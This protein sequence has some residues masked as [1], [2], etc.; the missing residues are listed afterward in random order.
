MNSKLK[1]YSFSVSMIAAI[2]FLI[3]GSF[4]IGAAQEGNKQTGEDDSLI[5]AYKQARTKDGEDSADAEESRFSQRA[6]LTASDGAANDEFG[7][8]VAISGDTAVVS[9]WHDDIGTNADQGSAY[10]FVR[11]GASWILQQKLTASDGAAGDNFGYSVAV[12]NVN[13]PSQTVIM[14]GAYGNDA[15]GPNRGAVYVFVR[16]QGGTSWSQQGKL[17]APDGV[18]N[19]AFGNAVAMSGNFAIIGANGVDIGAN[20]SS[21]AAY[22]F[23]RSGTIWVFEQKL[24]CPEG[25][26]TQRNFGWS[27]SIS[28]TL[29]IVGSNHLNSDQGWAYVF[30]RVTGGNTWVWRIGFQGAGKLGYSVG[31]SGET[32][33]MSAYGADI[34]SNMDQG[35][36]PV[37]CRIGGTWTYQGTLMASDGAANDYFGYNIAISGDR[38][39]VGAHADDVSNVN[40][41]SAYVFTR[42]GT[43]WSQRQK[44]TA[45][46]NGAGDFFAW[47]VAING[48]TAIMGAIFDDIGANAN[49][50]SAYIFNFYNR[51]PFDFDGDKKT[52]IS[53]FR[54]GSG[55]WWIQRSSTGQTL[56][57]QFGTSTDKLVPGDYTGDGK[58]DIAFWRPS[59]GEWFILR[60]ENSTFYGFQFGANGDIPA[61]ADY[62]GDGKTDAIIFRPSTQQWF[63][64]KSSGGT[65]TIVFGGAND[66][67]VVADYDGDGRSDLAAFRPN[68]VNGA[69][70]RIRYTASGAVSPT[71][72]FGATTDKA[73]PGDY[74]GDGKDDIAVWRF[75]TGEWY[76]LR[77][78]DFNTSLFQF[79]AFSD[80]P[81]P[82]DYDG[83]GKF[84]FAVFRPS[85]S[86]W[87]V[88]RTTAGLL[89]Q[90]FGV[91]GDQP[92]PNA[93]VP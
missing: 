55:E 56:T 53:I 10:V 13:F 40:Q 82:G 84:D 71:Y 37:Y 69:E 70:W 4:T 21:G 45:Q 47:S 67:P 24:L 90:Q 52:D 6:K 9:S 88:Q 38:I 30:E 46:D 8:K 22:V 32:I 66:K 23:T 73:V 14:V 12:T 75:S 39:I 19:D 91:A 3:G 57:A 87:Y 17:T 31:V 28:G 27:V 72:A 49:Q 1:N 48:D 41:G 81:V 85:N 50:G 78:E 2:L 7:L 54:P 20:V 29:A 18:D 83:D 11:S 79:G 92:L 80:V 89:T 42:T 64:Q 58:A 36:A 65:D 59:T 51:T 35:Q 93:Y 33:V 61:P 74:T 76:V 62:D 34:G 68:G 25:G 26:L 44:L 86:T 60:S 5:E 63:I 43:T 15:G 16:S 77:S